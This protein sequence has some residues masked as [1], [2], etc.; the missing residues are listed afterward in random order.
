MEERACLSFL[1]ILHSCKLHW[2]N[3]HCSPKAILKLSASFFNAYIQLI[4]TVWR[5]LTVIYV[6]ATGYILLF[7][8]WRWFN[9]TSL[10]YTEW[11]KKKNFTAWGAND[12]PFSCKRQSHFLVNVMFK[13]KWAKQLFYPE[14]YSFSWHF[15]FSSDLNI[16]L[17][18]LILTY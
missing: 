8:N 9:V 10:Y 2:C 14:V 7:N 5:I 16:T 1:R 4:C 17:R 13:L 15:N 12:R 6:Y 18:F 3:A 11:E